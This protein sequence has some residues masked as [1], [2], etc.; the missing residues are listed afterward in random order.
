MRRITRLGWHPFLRINTGGTFR[1]Q[2][3][4]RG[5]ALKT[6]VPQPGTSWRGTGIAFKGSYR[7]LH[8]TLLA[9]WDAG[10]RPVVDPHRP[11]PTASDVCWYGL[12]AWVEQG[13]K[14]T[15]RADWRGSGR[16]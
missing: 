15:K 2:G 12:R 4:V 1:P 16:T 10:I 14:L 11:T 13:F 3:Q 8:C 6:L 5:V 9:R 7:Q